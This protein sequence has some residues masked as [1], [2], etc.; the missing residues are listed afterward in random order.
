MRNPERIEPLLIELTKL[1]K[2]FPDM[3]LGQLIYNAVSPKEPCPAIFYIEDDVLLEKLAAS[4]KKW[5]GYD[6]QL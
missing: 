1:W 4:I 5:E 6:K 3:R 2:R